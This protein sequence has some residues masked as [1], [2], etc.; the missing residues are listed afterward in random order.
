ML[1]QIST[2]FILVLVYI[3]FLLLVAAAGVLQATK[4]I[5]EQVRTTETSYR[6]KDDALESIRLNIYRIALAAR[7]ALLDKRP[8]DAD[9]VVVECQQEIESQILF[10]RQAADSASVARIQK[11]DEDVHVYLRTIYSIT[12][13]RHS[14]ESNHR[15]AKALPTRRVILDILGVLSSWNDR[16]FEAAQV[17]ISNSLNSLRG[18]FLTILGMILLLGTLAAYAG[19]CRISKIQMS[20]EESHQ[21]ITEARGKLKSLSNQLVLAQELERKALS[22]ELHDEIGQSILALKLELARSEKIARTEGSG[23]VDHLQ[24]IRAIADQTLRATKSISLGLRPP[25]LDD[26]GLAAA[27]NWFTAEF[28]NRT[29]ILVKLDADGELSLLSETHRTCVYR[30]VQESLTNCGRHSGARQ[31]L[32]SLDATDKALRLTI[33]DDGAGFEPGARIGAG[34]GLISMQERTAELGGTF[35][36]TSSEGA[37]TKIAIEIPK[38][39]VSAV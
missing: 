32:I 11:V 5:A 2:P 39:L 17:A 23:V 34:I 37:G 31:V 8:Q 16:N 6:K 28:S 3:L 12:R 29:G 26:L 33:T 20:N 1:Q 14:A 21:R 4:K 7:D 9:A 25:M 30:I 27:L 38:V 15:L 36:I 22:R 18:E 19:F 35:E 10:L 13:M 24:A